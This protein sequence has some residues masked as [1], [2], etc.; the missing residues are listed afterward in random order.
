MKW[1]ILFAVLFTCLVL[2]LLNTVPV[3][4]DP[5]NAPAPANIALPF[6]LVIVLLVVGVGILKLFRDE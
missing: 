6:V 4:T 1:L 2:F 3:D 5:L